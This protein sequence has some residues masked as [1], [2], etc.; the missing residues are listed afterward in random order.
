VL[1]AAGRLTGTPTAQGAYSFTIN[2]TDDDG[3]TAKK[4]FSLTVKPPGRSFF[5]GFLATLMGDSFS[6]SVSD[7]NGRF[8]VT[9]TRRRSDGSVGECLRALGAASST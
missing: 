6:K 2:V 9:R 7:E 8:L 3:T 4:A 5:A 1:E